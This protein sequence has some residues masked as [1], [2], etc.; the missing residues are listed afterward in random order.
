MWFVAGPEEMEEVPVPWVDTW[1]SM[2]SWTRSP[3]RERHIVDQ[4]SMKYNSI[5][6]AQKDVYTGV[7]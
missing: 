1:A 4:K 5:K 2:E 7:M 3:V 6:S